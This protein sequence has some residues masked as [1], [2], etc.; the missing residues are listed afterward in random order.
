VSRNLPENTDQVQFSKDPIK[1][2]PGYFFL[3]GHSGSYFILPVASEDN[4]SLKR[5]YFS[6]LTE[7]EKSIYYERRFLNF[8]Y[9][10][11]QKIYIFLLRFFLII[12]MTSKIFM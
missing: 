11:R 6:Q 1:N 4:P 2:I 10:R 8:E 5:L 12:I 9:R 7:D 3:R